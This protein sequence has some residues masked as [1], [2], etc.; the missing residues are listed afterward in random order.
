MYQTNLD[1]T[2]EVEGIAS[3]LDFTSSQRQMEMQ[4]MMDWNNCEHVILCMKRRRSLYEK[5]KVMSLYKAR[6]PKYV[7]GQVLS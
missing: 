2:G 4:N 5:E 3:H 6:N 7:P 1:H